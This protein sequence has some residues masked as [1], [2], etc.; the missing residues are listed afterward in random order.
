MRFFFPADAAHTASAIVSEESSRT[1]VFA[2]PSR[3]S[4][5]FD[6]PSNAARYADR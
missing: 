3:M 2:A 1:A 4:S 5:R 6:A